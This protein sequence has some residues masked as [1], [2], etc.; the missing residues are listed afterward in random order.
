MRETET[1]S[2]RQTDRRT[3]KEIGVAEPTCEA[4][5]SKGKTIWPKMGQEAEGGKEKIEKANN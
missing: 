1:E 2:Q 3:H 5:I 4:M